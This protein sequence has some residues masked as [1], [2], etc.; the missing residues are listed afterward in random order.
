MGR[1]LSGYGTQF[2]NHCFIVTNHR[3]QR[4]GNEMKFV[5]NNQIRSCFTHPIMN[6]ENGLCLRT[7]WKHCKLI[8]CS[9]Q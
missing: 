9:K 6:S 4:T 8:N 1:L 2:M 7:K 5:L 3:P